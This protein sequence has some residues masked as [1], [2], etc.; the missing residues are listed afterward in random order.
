MVNVALE[1]TVVKIIFRETKKCGRFSGLFKSWTPQTDKVR[2]STSRI[3]EFKCADSWH[4]YSYRL[5]MEK[6]LRSLFGLHVHSCIHWLRPRNP[7]PTHLGSYTRALL[8]SQ[9]RRYLFVTP[10]L[11]LSKPTGAK[12][13]LASIPLLTSL[14][15]PLDIHLKRVYKLKQAKYKY[16]VRAVLTPV[17]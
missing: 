17:F 14:K 15:R 2:C 7:S 16:R 10:W 9:D 6:D 13:A 12:P 3:T 5:N 11:Q 1:Y 8:V 4:Y